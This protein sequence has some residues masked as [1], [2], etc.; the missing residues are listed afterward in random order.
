LKNK[1]ALRVL[2]K[3]GKF[4]ELGNKILEEVKKVLKDVDDLFE[5]IKIIE[6]ID[7]ENVKDL[8]KNHLKN[9]FGGY[10]YL[11]Y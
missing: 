1:Y 7:I 2:K 8:F 10:R 9:V 3:Y 6:K 4:T 11:K 5:N